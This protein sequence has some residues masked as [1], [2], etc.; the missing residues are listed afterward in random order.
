MYSMSRLVSVTIVFA[1]NS[2]LLSQ[3]AP[4]F[5]CNR[6]IAANV[7]ALDQPI[8]LNRL[9]SEIPGGMIYALARDVV[10]T[11][12]PGASCAAAGCK[13]GQVRLRDDKRPRPIALRLGVGDCLT[14]TMTNLVTPNPTPDNLQISTSNTVGTRWGQNAT[15]SVGF[16]VAGLDLLPGAPPPSTTP[17]CNPKLS[18]DAN[19][20]GANCSSLANPGETKSY[21][22]YGRDE[23]VYLVY[24]NDDGLNSSGNSGQQQAG[25]FGSVMVEPRNAEFFRSQVTRTD[26]EEAA[27]VACAGAPTAGCVPKNSFSNPRFGNPMML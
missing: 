1:S 27:F 20:V 24:S 2:F 16:H 3:P 5:A 7:I 19:W 12:N 22:Y 17:P 21:Q 4:P 14:I 6:A 9:G 10:S 23:G 15:R 18:S 8:M 25:L 11:E 13:P 26:L